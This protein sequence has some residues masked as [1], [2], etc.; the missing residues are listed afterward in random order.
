MA[1]LSKILLFKFLYIIRKAFTLSSIFSKDPYGKQ[2]GLSGEELINLIGKY[3][4]FVSSAQLDR[5]YF[6][7]GNPGI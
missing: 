6:I 1:S 5:A 7:A 4:E 2:G 3:L